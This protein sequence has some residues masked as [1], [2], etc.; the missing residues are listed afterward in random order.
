MLSRNSAN[1]QKISKVRLHILS[2]AS[3]NSVLDEK[4]RSFRFA[5][6]PFEHI[7]RTDFRRQVMIKKRALNGLKTLNASRVPFVK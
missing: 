4:R 3:S 1:S 2:G 6:R 7:S 5:S